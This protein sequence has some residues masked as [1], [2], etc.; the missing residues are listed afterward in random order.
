[1]TRDNNAIRGNEE[2]ATIDLHALYKT[3][4]HAA[5]ELASHLNASNSK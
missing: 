5:I 2:F 4:K 1:M 3:N